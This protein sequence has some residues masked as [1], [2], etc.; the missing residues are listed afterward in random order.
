MPLSTRENARLI[1]QKLSRRCQ[2]NCK[3][4]KFA[5]SDE[6]FRIK[7]APKHFFLIGNLCCMK[8]NHFADGNYARFFLVQPTKPVEIN[9]IT[10][11]TQIAHNLHQMT[12]KYTK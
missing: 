3:N 9:Q 7:K 2:K 1:V 5:E 6:I 4:V 12:I 11:N 8:C 10:K